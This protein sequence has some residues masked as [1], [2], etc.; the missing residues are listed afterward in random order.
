MWFCPSIFPP[1]VCLQL[2]RLSSV[3][4]S[5]REST[6]AHRTQCCCILV[7]VCSCH[8]NYRRSQPQF[9]PRPV[10]EAATNCSQ[11]PQSAQLY[12]P[13]L[14]PKEPGCSCP[15]AVLR[16]SMTHIQTS[17]VAAAVV[18][19]FPISTCCLFKLLGRQ[20]RAEC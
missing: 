13:Y 2:S 19:A 7:S 11:N 9:H 20:D 14:V 8:Y 16:T 18:T 15:A 3:F 1:P 12:L 6:N 4:E 17:R 5:F 10:R